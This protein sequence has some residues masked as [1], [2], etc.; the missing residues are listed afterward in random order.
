M[1][2]KSG[3]RNWDDELAQ[4]IEDEGCI[5]NIYNNGK[6]GRQNKLQN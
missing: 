6:T 4:I 3:V 1:E 2:K 5:Q